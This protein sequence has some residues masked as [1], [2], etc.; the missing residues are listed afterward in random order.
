M[1]L[2][3]RKYKKRFKY[4]KENYKLKKHSKIRRTVINK[5]HYIYHA[6]VIN[7]MQKVLTIKKIL[8]IFYTGSIL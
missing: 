6:R 8:N 1:L 2:I 7:E 4:L 5:H 3:Q